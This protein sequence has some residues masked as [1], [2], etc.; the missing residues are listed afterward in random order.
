[1]TLRRQDNGD[2]AAQANG[3][4]GRGGRGGGGGG[5]NDFTAAVSSA[6]HF[7]ITEIPAGN[8]LLT[9]SSGRR[10]GVLHNEAVVVITGTTSDVTVS[11]MTCSLEGTVTVD[12]GSKV[13]ALQGGMMLLPGLTEVPENI[14]QLARDGT[15]F[16]ARVAVGKFAIDML[17]PGN[18]LAV[19]RLAGR[20]T[21]SAQTFAAIGQKITLTMPAGKTS[22]PGDVTNQGG[23]AR[24]AG[25]GRGGRGANGAAGNPNGATAPAAGPRG[26]G[27]GARGA[28]GAGGAGA[29]G[30]ARGAGGAGGG[31]TGNTGGGN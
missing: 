17:P 30:G 1:V 16:N 3:R 18:Y 29:G 23:G 7:T 14:N 15:S 22:P 24:G 26:A 4:G 31:A 6:S 8:Y 2:P 20:E 11:L 19:L 13:E 9:I 21:T 5:G 28:G 10:A 25:G 27:G 12:D